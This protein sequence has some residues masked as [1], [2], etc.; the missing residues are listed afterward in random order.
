M[1]L[2]RPLP[3]EDLREPGYQIAPALEVEQWL[4]A[5]VA[6]D[7]AERN[8]DHDHLR[9]ADIA[10]LWTNVEYADGLVRIAGTAELVKPSGKPWPKARAVDHL[11]LL[12]G[13]VPDFLLTFSAP[14]AA[15]AS[16]AA[17]CAL[18]EHELYH[19][20]QKL[21]RD[22]LP[23]FDPEGKPVWA[24]QRHDVEE[25]I[26][27]VE[28]YGVGACHENVRKMVQAAAK[29]PLFNGERIAVVCGACR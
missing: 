22:K 11:C 16:D 23:K 19:C 10:C 8:P 3:P 9:E 24:M 4:R 26:G 5:F 6:E 28:R 29:P 1:I 20:G 18:V 12:F 7:A 27:V 13:R 21:D 15:E 25:F 2:T 17:W 14:L